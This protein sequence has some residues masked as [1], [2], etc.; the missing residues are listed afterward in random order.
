[1]D[2][3][4]RDKNGLTE[5]EFL[6]SYRVK[7][8]PRPSV[9]VDNVVLL[10]DG[11]KESILLIKRGGHPYIGMHALPGGFSSPSETVYEAAARELLEETGAKGLKSMLVGVYSTP[12]RDPRNWVMSVAFL[13][14]IEKEIM[15]EGMDDATMASFFP[16]THSFD[17]KESILTFE[18]KAPDEEIRARVKISTDSKESEIIESNGLA[19]D[20]AKIIADCIYASRKA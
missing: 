5:E 2:E 3:Q 8:Y 9:T 4:R 1:M 12:K 6:K 18:V 14:K 11:E 19:F 20:H 13:S 17:E 15:V 10:A 7:D 16:L